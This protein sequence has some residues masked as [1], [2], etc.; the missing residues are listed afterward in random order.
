MRILRWTAVTLGVLALSGGLQTARATT[1]TFASFTEVDSPT[2]KNQFKFVN[3]GQHNSSAGTLSNIPVNG[4]K[5][6]F[7]YVQS[8]IFGSLPADLAGN[9][10]SHT[11]VNITTSSTA[12]VG[13][14]FDIQPFMAG[15]ISF[16]RDTAAL[17]GT[18][19]KRNLLTVTFSSSLAGQ[20]H[21]SVAGLS[22]SI[23]SGQT[24]T[25]TS[26]FLTF[27]T[28]TDAGASLSLSSITPSLSVSLING[29]LNSFKAFGTGS[30]ASSPAPSYGP[31]P[32]PGTLALAFSALPLLGLAVLRRRRR[33]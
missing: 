16:I 6:Q 25:F 26:D 17:E 27:P 33:A 24:V 20:T 29:I 2:Q 1:V 3:D 13:G 23:S 10:N 5:T 15:T 8:G 19:S 22:G 30:F 11:F 14:G 21:S 18:G 7:N 28:L 12:F 9:Q 4:I 32:E 31:V